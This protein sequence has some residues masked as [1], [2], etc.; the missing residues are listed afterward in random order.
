MNVAVI[1]A[2]DK[3]ERYSYRVC[4]LL[5][6]KGHRIFPVH[7]RITDIEGMTVYPSILDVP[8]DIDTVSMYVAPDKSSQIAAD[9]LQVHPKR[10]I[11]NPGAENP[12]LAEQAR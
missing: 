9:I 11:F 6:E 4:M 10:I 2:S 12:D 7:G 1:G 3:P 5:K 8:Q